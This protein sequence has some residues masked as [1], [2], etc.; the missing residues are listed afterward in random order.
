M[1]KVK[2]ALRILT[3]HLVGEVAIA[4]RLCYAHIVRRDIT[5]G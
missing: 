5:N 2:E 1:A 4:K 3:Q